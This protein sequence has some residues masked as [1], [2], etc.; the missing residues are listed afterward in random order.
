MSSQNR[1]AADSATG[2]RGTGRKLLLMVSSVL[3]TLVTLEVLTRLWLGCIAGEKQFLK[4]ASLKQLNRRTDIR[5]RYS[6]HRYLGHYLTPGYA[7]GENRH[8]SLGY[9]SDEIVVPKPEGQFR[10]V[11]L[12]GSTTYTTEIDDYR[13]SYPNLLQEELKERGYANVRVI[14]GGVGAWTSWESLVNFEF[15]ILDLEPD[16]IIV[17]HA[18]NDVRARFV[19]PHEAYRGDNSGAISPLEMSMPSILEYSTLMRYVM[20]RMGLVKPHS[21][22]DRHLAAQPPTNLTM[23]FHQQNRKSTYPDGVFREVRA[24]QILAANPPVY[25]RRNIEHMVVIAKH[26]GIK[27]VL[28]T[29]ARSTEFPEFPLVSSPECR[30]AYREMNDTLKSIAR[31]LDVHLFDFAAQFPTDR[32]YYTDG[33]HVNVEGVKLK[34]RLFADYLVDNQLI[35]VSP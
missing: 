21:S 3:I 9:R 25:F 15:R 11:C 4:Y 22:M 2:A 31:E 6:P 17:Y 18:V 8:N 26:R 13:K 20:I 33:V 14:N 29:F 23:E 19:W 12:G 28:V 34:A 27:T 16:M 35:S 30:A 10:I 7:Q 5:P 24:E 1:S 32:R